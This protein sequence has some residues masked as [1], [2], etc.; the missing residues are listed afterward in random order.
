MRGIRT[1]RRKPGVDQPLEAAC[2]EG[3]GRP[4]S[5]DFGEV[6][7]AVQL[8]VE[9]FEGVERLLVSLATGQ[10]AS[11][12][13]S[14][15]SGILELDGEALRKRTN[16][17]GTQGLGPL[18]DVVVGQE[19]LQGAPAFFGAAFLEVGARQEQAGIRRQVRD[20]AQKLAGD[21]R[22]LVEQGQGGGG[23]SDFQRL[24]LLLQGLSI[25]GECFGCA[26][27]RPERLAQPH[28]YRG[29]GRA[30]RLGLQQ[31]NEV[32]HAALAGVALFEGLRRLEV[33]GEEALEALPPAGGLR[34]F[35][36]MGLLAAKGDQALA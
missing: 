29:F 32:H 18:G 25:E 33:A 24:G 30:F 5:Q 14:R 23:P 1:S 11:P 8:A 15:P 2:I 21:S 7:G 4:Q 17:F 35:G 34:A 22:L 16:D 19:R 6:L 36:G 20:L 28:D 26:V 3:L 27:D 31:P 13:G 12:P 10:E 9:G